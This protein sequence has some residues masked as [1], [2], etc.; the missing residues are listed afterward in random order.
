M[1]IITP[2]PKTVAKTTIVVTAQPTV[3]LRKVGSKKV[4]YDATK[5]TVVYANQVQFA[6]D[7]GK[8]GAVML[9]PF[10]GQYGGTVDE[11]EN[12]PD[13]VKTVRQGLMSS[14]PRLQSRGGGG[15]RTKGLEFK[16]SGSYR[17][18]HLASLAEL[19]QVG[20]YGADAALIKFMQ[21]T[22]QDQPGVQFLA[23][24]LKA[25]AEYHPF[26]YQVIVESGTSMMLPTRHFHGHDHNP[27]DWD[28]QI[29]TV[30][31]D[32]VTTDDFKQPRFTGR[33]PSRMRSNENGSFVFKNEAWE[34]VLK[35]HPMD[36]LNVVDPKQ[37][38]KAYFVDDWNVNTDINVV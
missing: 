30:N 2:S 11:L 25:G 5:Y 21:D 6:Q 18:A 23:C 22:Y 10:R 24:Y 9:L 31:C 35:K 33:S 13:L 27:L 34:R 37:P 28:H 29:Y 12:H 1:C 17:V 15:A 16:D 20:P 4:S 3:A 38:P 14:Y 8:D 19:E 36:W 7:P 26:G 32:W